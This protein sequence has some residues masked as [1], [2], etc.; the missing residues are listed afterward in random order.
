MITNSKQ[1]WEVGEVVK[2]GFMK[3]RVT[4]KELTPGD[5]SP[6]AYLLCGIGDKANNVYR[7][8]PHKGIERVQQ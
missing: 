3:L 7:F 8:V 6:D 1:S 5:Y 4:A 2:V